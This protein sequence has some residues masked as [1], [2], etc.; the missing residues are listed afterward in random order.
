MKPSNGSSQLNESRAGVN[1]R[2]KKLRGLGNTFG[3]KVR[4]NR[5]NTNI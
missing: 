4:E 1:S 3:Q 5:R 2:V